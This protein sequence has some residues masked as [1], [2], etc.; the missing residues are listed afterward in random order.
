VIRV[1]GRRLQLRERRS[2]AIDRLDGVLRIEDDARTA[3]EVEALLR[4]RDRERRTRRRRGSAGAS[5]GATLPAT[6]YLHR[7][8]DCHHGGQRNE[9]GTSIHGESPYHRDALSSTGSPNFAASIGTLNFTSVKVNVSRPS[10][11]V[12]VHLWGNLTPPTS[13]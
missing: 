8:R 10:S 13:R 5:V 4:R 9:Q 2:N 1:L 7:D 6:L 3:R 12:N 11:H